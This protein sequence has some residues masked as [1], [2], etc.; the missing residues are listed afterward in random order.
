VIYASQ[1]TGLDTN[2]CTQASPCKTIAFGASN[3]RTGYPDHLLLKAG[4]VWT[5][6]TFNDGGGRF[7]QSGVSASQ[8]ILLGTYGSG[9]RPKIQSPINNPANYR[10]AVFGAI[11]A[12]D[13]AFVA[14]QGIEMYAYTRDPANASFA[15]TIAVGA[16]TNT[17]AIVSYNTTVNNLLWIEDCKISFYNYAVDQETGYDASNNPVPVSGYALT[18]YRNIILNSYTSV[19]G[20]NSA[21]VYLEGA[22][23]NVLEQNLMDTNGWSPN[24]GIQGVGGGPT[25]KNRN[26]YIQGAPASASVQPTVTA[27]GNIFSNG[28]TNEQFR[29]GG[30]VTNNLFLQQLLMCFSL[31]ENTGTSFPATSPTITSSTIVGNVCLNP[32]DLPANSFQGYAAVPGGGGMALAQLSGSGI[33]FNNNIFATSNAAS[34]YYNA[35]LLDWDSSNNVTAAATNIGFLFKAGATTTSGSG[36]DNV[37]NGYFDQNGINTGG[38]PDPFPHPSPTAPGSTS[39]AGDY[40][41]SINGGTDAS[42]SGYIAAG[43]ARAGGT[44]PLNLGAYQANAYVQSG[45]NMTY[46]STQ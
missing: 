3:I 30:I 17:N 24:A 27:D 7:R 5:N 34:P 15:G 11:A 32:K 37:W 38:S 14:I 45:F 40:Y 28:S 35:Y 46:R 10:G 36:T 25:P 29:P 13:G 21:G 44:W 33:A 23:T 16:D 22:A 26:V 31:G 42:V 2:P 43:A 18:L 19:L 39:L 6:D 4:D 20:A 8:P 41:Y 9:A 1:S 12:T